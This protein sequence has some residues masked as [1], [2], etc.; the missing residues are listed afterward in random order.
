MK[1][2]ELFG[3]LL[4]ILSLYY[5]IN[6]NG[7]DKAVIKPPESDITIDI[8]WK[9]GLI[10][11][12]AGKD[13]IHVFGLEDKTSL[14]LRTLD[15]ENILIRKAKIKHQPITST[16]YLYY[17]LLGLLWGARAD[18]KVRDRDPNPQGYSYVQL[19]GKTKDGKD[20]AY[21]Y[22]ANRNGEI[23]V[24]KYTDEPFSKPQDEF[25]FY[26]IKY[27]MDPVGITEQFFNFFKDVTSITFAGGMK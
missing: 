14:G 5:T 18:K 24:E 27:I 23:Y 17:T 19:Y 6:L 10:T 15:I 25:H 22:A 12:T 3:E 13:D 1:T 8:E 16:L 20:M 2:K 9:N 4:G 21:L 7:I 26:P 11:V